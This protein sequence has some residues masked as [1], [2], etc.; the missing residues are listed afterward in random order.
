MKKIFLTVFVLMFFVQITAFAQGETA[1]N[2]VGSVESNE[3]S[4][5]AAIGISSEIP[6]CGISFDLI[7]NNDVLEFSDLKC[8]EVLENAAVVTN[9]NYTDN[10]IRIVCA[11]AAALPQNGNVVTV[12]FSYDTTGSEIDFEI[13]NCKIV[14]VN[15]EKLECLINNTTLSIPNKENNKKPTDGGIITTLPSPEK[16]EN[17]N[18]ENNDGK[19]SSDKSESST[20]EKDVQKNLEDEDYEV[21]L[22]SFDDVYENDWFYES[23]KYVFEQKLM[24]GVS[25]TEFAPNANLT[26][27][28]LV[29]ILYRMEN[30]PPCKSVRF[31]DV[32][33]DMWYTNAIAWAFENGI[34]KGMG[35]GLFAPNANITREQIAQILCNYEKYK[36]ESIDCTADLSR[37]TDNSSVSK[38][39]EEAVNWAVKNSIVTGK[40][41]TTLEPLGQAARAEAAAMLMR[42]LT[43]AK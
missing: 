9:E 42:Y 38:W 7:Y 32:E 2:I 10:S 17:K 41:A 35:N 15:N 5:S 3:K 8:G 13:E 27:A 12:T 6:F 30:E 37:F 22:M 40:T 31:D 24:N 16:T 21:F 18:S 20:N 25:T 36:N 26:R 29:T 28:M 39:A 4:V 19:D 33:T 1:M 14:G 43:T 23:V 34:V 11:S